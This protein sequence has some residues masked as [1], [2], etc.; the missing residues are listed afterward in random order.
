MATDNRLR[1][2]RVIAAILP[3]S[4]AVSLY[5]SDLVATWIVALIALGSVPPLVR[6]AFGSEEGR[7]E[8][9]TVS[10]EIE[11]ARGK[12]D[13]VAPAIIDSLP[14]ALLAIDQDLIVLETNKAARNLLGEG[15]RGRNIGL[16]LR[17]PAAL[18]AIEEAL[19]K[20]ETVA[21]ELSLLTPGEQ[22]FV[23]QVIPL[24][25]IATGM[26][27]RLSALTWLAALL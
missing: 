4:V 20:D 25:H 19:E 6:L 7:H 10:T 11:P 18:E 3:V 22:F 5:Y 14:D 1:S 26:F 16:S 24:T 8:V 13:G 27:K 17:R 23:M 9:A 2:N 15:L 21:L 12:L